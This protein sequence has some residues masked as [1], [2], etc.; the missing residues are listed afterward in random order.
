MEA[1][2]L[3]HVSWQRE[4]ASFGEEMCSQVSFEL[5]KLEKVPTYTHCVHLHS[6]KVFLHQVSD[7]HLVG[8]QYLKLHLITWLFGFSRKS[9]HLLTEDSH[10]N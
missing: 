4:Y 7:I 1:E 6:H 9:L 5:K 8:M 10:H 2:T 3:M